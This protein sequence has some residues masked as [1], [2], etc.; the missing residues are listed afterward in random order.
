MEPLRILILDGHPDPDPDRF[1]HAL[2]AAYA[3]GAARAGHLVHRTRLADLDF[4]FLQSRADWEGGAPCEAVLRVQEELTRANHLVVI[5]PLWLGS[6]PARLKGLME[7]VMRPHFAFGGEA[8]GPGAGRLKG[9]SAR[10]IVTMGM[11]AIIYRTWFG[12]HSLK[13][14]RSGVLSLAGFR[15]IRDTVLGGVETRRDR[16]DVLRWARRLGMRGR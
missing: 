12:S 2:A 1:C 16:E 3:E 9:R 14:F 11:P 8:V 7:Q 6:M 5:Y 15:P 4:P 10:I 13:A